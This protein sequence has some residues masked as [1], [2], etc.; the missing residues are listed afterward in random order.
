MNFFSSIQDSIRRKS[1]ENRERKEFLKLVDE[2]TLPIKR[3]A[4]LEEMKKHAYNEGKEKA[5]KDMEARLQ[6]TKTRSDFGIDADPYKF[7]KKTEENKWIQ[8]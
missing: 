3:K 4:Y 5:K 6:K 1:E 8:N 7:L 2:E